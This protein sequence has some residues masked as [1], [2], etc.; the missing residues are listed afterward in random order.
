M[1]AIKRDAVWHV[2]TFC[3]L[4]G[5]FSFGQAG[6]KAAGLGRALSVEHHCLAL[7]DEGAEW[8]QVDGVVFTWSPCF[9]SHCI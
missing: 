7:W 4:Q 1:G 8:H 5:C 2:T 9:L 3:L 6:Q